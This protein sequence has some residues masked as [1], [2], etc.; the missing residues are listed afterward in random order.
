M[1]S[2]QIKVRGLGLCSGG[3]DSRL[4]AMVLRGQ[5]IYVEWVTFETPFFS[6]ARAQQASRL[7]EVPLTVKDIT[8]PYLKMLENPPCGYGHSS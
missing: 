6:A 3:L 4:A 2:D 8:R 5:G 7:L 1:V